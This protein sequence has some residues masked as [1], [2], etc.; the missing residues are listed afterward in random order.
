MSL[1][2]FMPDVRFWLSGVNILLKSADVAGALISS[3]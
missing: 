1:A 3:A 2:D